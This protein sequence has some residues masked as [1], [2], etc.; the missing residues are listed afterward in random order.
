MPKRKQLPDGSWIIVPDMD[1]YL[2]QFTSDPRSLAQYYFG[3]DEEE[4][5]EED[6]GTLAGSAWE[7]FKSIPSG[8]ADIFLSG[9]KLL[10]E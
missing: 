7:G 6:E 3:S 5:E 4:E 8:V 2:Q 9:A 10:L 1:P